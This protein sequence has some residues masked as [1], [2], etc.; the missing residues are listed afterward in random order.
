MS[1]ARFDF[2]RSPSGIVT[3]AAA[4]WIAWR[5]VT[6]GMADLLVWS[7]P[8]AATGWRVAHPAAQYE[9][10]QS[11]LLAQRD[12]VAMIHARIGIASNPLDGRDYRIAAAVAE[13]AGDR[14]GAE[15][16]FEIAERRAPRDLP[17]RIKLAAYA[18]R[19]GDHQRALHEVDM[20]LRMQPE[21]DA[22]VLPRLVRLTD[23]ATAIDPIARIL[24][25]HPAWRNSFL[26]ML[27][28]S[29]SDP[30]S[31]DRLFAR[32]QAEDRLTP[33]ETDAL[34]TLQRRI[35]DL[36]RGSAPAARKADTSATT[37]WYALMDWQSME[38]KAYTLTEDAYDSVGTP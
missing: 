29:A 34:K 2:L 33:N 17:T 8:A 15:R 7:D 19:A 25:Q 4:A 28:G 37:D 9:A 31:A 10:A 5:C 27:A 35:E 24:L 20:L 16:L 32:L 30:L 11:D 36:T 1:R 14:V 21:L 3:L 38:S 23:D 26:S 6:M 18:L 12:A 22:D 13:S